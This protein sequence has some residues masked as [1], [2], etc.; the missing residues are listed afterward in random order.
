MTSVVGKS[1]DQETHERAADAIEE[2]I[3]THTVAIIG[4][5][6]AQ[7]LQKMGTGTAISY[8]GGHFILTARHVVEDTPDEALRFFCRPEGSLRRAQRAELRS[9]QQAMRVEDMYLIERIPILGRALCDADDLAV[10]SVTPDIKER[11]RVQ[12]Y[13]FDDT[14]TAP[15]A[16]QVVIAMGYPSDIARQI[17]SGNFVAFNSVE[18]TEVVRSSPL[19]DFD[20]SRH[21]LAPYHTVEDEPGAHPRGFSG[22]GVWHRIGSTPP[23]KLW[24]PN[25]LLAGVFIT[26]YSGSAMLKAVRIES[27]TEFLQSIS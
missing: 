8:R 14:Q 22:C 20:P 12:F 15:E 6:G 25:P 19:D 5:I 10:L 3:A 27:V 21:F 17:E 4:G 23:G 1:Q 13:D 26:Y 24:M 16:G 18:W 2:A 7:A 11:H 9:F